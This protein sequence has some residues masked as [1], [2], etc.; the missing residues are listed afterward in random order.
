M[1]SFIWRVPAPTDG[2]VNKAN[3]MTSIH[4]E[5]LRQLSADQMV[6]RAFNHLIVAREGQLLVA[7]LTL[8]AGRFSKML[9]GCPVPWEEVV[10]LIDAPLGDFFALPEQA[11]IQNHTADFYELIKGS[12]LHWDFYVDLFD[13][14]PDV[15]P[16]F[17]RL[18]HPSGIRFAFVAPS[19]LISK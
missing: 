5:N 6:Y 13:V 8:V 10:G 7:P 19:G 18:T 14:A 9:D 2:K 12:R 15:P 16:R 11:E 1:Y 3:R 17:V 4:I